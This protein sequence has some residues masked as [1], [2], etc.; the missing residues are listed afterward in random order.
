MSSFRHSSSLSVP[1]LQVMQTLKQLADD[2]HTVVCSIHQVCP[3]Q[4]FQHIGPV[5]HLLWTVMQFG[6]NTQAM[7]PCTQP[8]SSIFELF[9][10][11]LL[12]TEGHAVYAGPAADAVEYFSKKGHPCPD[13][14]NP[15]E[16]LADLISV[17][18]SSPEAE[19]KTRHAQSGNQLTS[20]ALASTQHSMKWRL[21][22]AMACMCVLG[23]L[24]GNEHTLQP[25]W[26]Q[27][28]TLKHAH[29]GYGSRSSLTASKSSTGTLLPAQRR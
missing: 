7:R 25:T 1:N 2:G 9:D 12:L 11:L 10:D 19:Q 4:H 8:R 24:R 15:A 16:F 17:D 5:C 13:R 14:Y 21:I 22:I 6:S 26:S 23:E 28:P 20:P 18:T 27:M 29:A 3:T